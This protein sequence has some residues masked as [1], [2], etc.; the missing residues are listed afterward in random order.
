MKIACYPGTFDPL[1]IGHVDV[2]YRARKIFDQVIILLAENSNK[3]SHFFTFEERIEIARE[4][5]PEKD[6]FLV[7]STK[8]LVVQKAKELGAIALIRGLRAVT[9]Y[10]AEYQMH[11]VNEYIEP[12][13]DMIYL[14][15]HRVQAFVSSSNIKEM[16]LQGAD[17]SGLVPPAVLEA[18]KK[19][20]IQNS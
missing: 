1:T 18:M 11:E 5:F 17:I 6:G 20:K 2:A 14:M 13:I 12:S 4:V 15:S 9:D 3:R 8:G 16:F 10:E 19:K 7:S